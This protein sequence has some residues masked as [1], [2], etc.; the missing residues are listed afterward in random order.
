MRNSA[1]TVIVN[2][3]S[4]NHLPASLNIEVTA[5]VHAR[6]GGEGDVCTQMYTLTTSK[7]MVSYLYNSASKYQRIKF[8]SCEFVFLAAGFAWQPKGSAQVHCNLI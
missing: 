3:L 6:E 1:A 7:E 5:C 8:F 4:T 2:R